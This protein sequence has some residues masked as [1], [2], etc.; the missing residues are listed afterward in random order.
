MCVAFEGESLIAPALQCF[1]ET[2]SV[3]LVHPG[4]AS[5][6]SD[7]PLFAPGPFGP[8]LLP[9]S[10]SRAC[11]AAQHTSAEQREGDARRNQAHNPNKE[12]STHGTS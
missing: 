7:P 12:P 11:K 5:P 1:D 6:A 4:V 10:A 9:S 3:S 8:A 2:L